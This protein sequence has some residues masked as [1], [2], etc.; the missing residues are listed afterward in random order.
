MTKLG[1][2]EI[3]PEASMIDDQDVFARGG[4]MSDAYWPRY[5]TASAD[6]M[7]LHRVARHGTKRNRAGGQHR[8]HATLLPPL[9]PRPIQRGESDRWF[10]TN[11]RPRATRS[12]RCS[13]SA[14]RSV[15]APRVRA[16]R[17]LTN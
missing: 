10:A 5:S 3:E 8:R 16:S 17:Y 11:S 6:V 1:L 2:A 15:G 4:R 13:R 9:S 7:A 14:P 12:Q